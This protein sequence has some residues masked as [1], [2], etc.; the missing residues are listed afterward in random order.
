MDSTSWVTR[1]SLSLVLWVGVSSRS[2][3]FVFIIVFALWLWGYYFLNINN[4]DDN[5]M[6]SF[7][8]IKII[9]DCVD[10]CPRVYQNQEKEQ[11]RRDP[12]LE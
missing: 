1:E 6:D 9:I 12:V 2:C 10:H 8:K 7:I 11:Y 4:N 3:T 5:K